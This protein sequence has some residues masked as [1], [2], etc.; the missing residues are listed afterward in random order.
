MKQVMHPMTN[1]RTAIAAIQEGSVYPVTRVGREAYFMFNIDK[2]GSGNII[3]TIFN[4]DKIPVSSHMARYGSYHTLAEIV[5]NPIPKSTLSHIVDLSLPPG[6][7]DI[8]DIGK[9]VTSY[10]DQPL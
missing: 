1:I 6:I 9:I 7:D 2:V 10:K 4:V 8:I 3:Y 5:C